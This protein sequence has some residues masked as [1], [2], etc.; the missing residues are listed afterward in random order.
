MCIFFFLVSFSYAF[1]TESERINNHTMVLRYKHILCLL[2]LRSWGA[3]ARTAHRKVQFLYFLFN[4][5]TLG[6]L[7]DTWVY[8]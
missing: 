5:Q 7:V 3:I 4:L 1:I 8:S 2:R 6:S